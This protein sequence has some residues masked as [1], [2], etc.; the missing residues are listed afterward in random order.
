MKLRLCVM[1]MTLVFAV[2][3]V[4]AVVFAADAE[5]VHGDTPVAA[6]AAGTGDVQEGP[7]VVAEGD[8][9]ADDGL[10]WVYKDDASLTISGAG[11]IPNYYK[12][13]QP[14]N[15][16][17]RTME[18]LA[19]EE[20]VTSIGNYAFYEADYLGVGEI[21]LP[22]TLQAIGNYAFYSCGN[23]KEVTFLA[24]VRTLGS[25]V[26]AECRGITKVVLPDTVVSIGSNSFETCYNVEE[27]VL[28]DGLETIPSNL[29]HTA[30]GSS[31]VTSLK[32]PSNLKRVESGAFQGLGAL[33]GLDLPATLS[34]VGN[35]G[36][37]GCR[38]MGD[39]RIPA[40]IETVGSSA[41]GMFRVQ[42]GTL[43][44]EEGVK[45]SVFDALVDYNVTQASETWVA[46]RIRIPASMGWSDAFKGGGAR[47]AYEVAIG[48]DCYSVVDGV[49]YSRGPNNRYASTGALLVSCPSSMSG[50]FTVAK[51]AL[52]MSYG[53][54]SKLFTVVNIP[55]SVIAI[56][57][58]VFKEAK[59]VDV[60]V[61]EGNATFAS[62]DGI[63]FDKGLTRVI[64]CPKGNA[65]EGDYELPDTVR[66]LDAQAFE[67][68]RNLKSIRIPEGVIAMPNKFM[69]DCDS[70]VAVYLPSTLVSIGTFN[71]WESFLPK[72]RSG[73][74]VFFGGTEDGLAAVK[75]DRSTNTAFDRSKFYCEATWHGTM[76]NGLLWYTDVS[77]ALNIVRDERVDS[78]RSDMADYVAGSAPWSGHLGLFDTVS[79]AS[80]IT[81][82][83]S[84]A[85]AGCP[86]IESVTLSW[87]IRQV[88]SGAFANC[89]SLRTVDCL[90][91]AFSVVAADGQ[92]PSFDADVATLLYRPETTG[93]TDAP[94]YDSQAR[95]WNGYS[96]GLAEGCEL[97][98]IAGIEFLDD[99]GNPVSEATVSGLLGNRQSY[100][101]TDV[102]FSFKVLA[103]DGS[104]ITDKVNVRV[105]SPPRRWS[106]VSGSIGFST[107]MVKNLHL[108]RSMGVS[109]DD[110]DSTVRVGCCSPEG[111]YVITAAP[112]EFESAGDEISYAIDVKRAQERI[113]HAYFKS[114]ET[115]KP[116]EGRAKISDSPYTDTYEVCSQ[117]MEDVTS[118]VQLRVFDVLSRVEVTGALAERGM[119]ASEDS[120]GT[121]Q[122]DRMA[123]PRDYELR[124]GD[125]SGV[126]SG[127]SSL[128]LG[129]KR[130]TELLN[131]PYGI[132]LSEG[133]KAM[134]VDTSA[135]DVWSSIPY[136]VRTLDA[137][138]D[139]CWPDLSW[140]V[141]DSG[142]RDASGG[143]EVDGQGYLRIGKSVLSQIQPGTQLTFSIESAAQGR[144]GIVS[145]NSLPLSLGA[146]PSAPEPVTHV[147]VFK[148]GDDV[149]GR[150]SFVEGDT[151]LVA[152]AV[153]SKANYV[154]TWAVGSV[155]WEEFDLSAA[156]S[157][158]EVSGVYEPIDPD[159]VS[160][161]E[162]D[163]DAK[164]E[165]GAVTVT[166][167]AKAASRNVRIE[168]TKTKPVD[169]V[170]VCDQSG[171]MSDA[172][173]SGQS[174]RDA[175]V[176][177]ANSFAS[178]LSDNAKKTGAG[179]RIALV[180]FGCAGRVYNSDYR[181]YQS[182]GILATNA[183]GF[184]QYPG[185]KKVYSEAL[186]PINEGQS[187][188]P[189]VSQ[190]ISSITCDAAT[191]ANLGFEIAKGIFSQ[192]PSA[193]DASVDGR[194][195]VVVFIT[196]GTPTS[197][198]STDGSQVG[199]T[200]S[201]AI[202]N[203]KYI[204]Q[205]QGARIFSVGVEVAANPSADFTASSNGMSG[206]GNRFSFDFNRFLHAVSS[207]YPEA[208]AM[209]NLGNGSKS[210][211]YYMAVN[212]TSALDGI[213]ESI[214]YST[215][216]TVESFDR[217]SFRYE[218]PEGL[219]LTLKQEEELRA[220]MSGQGM[221][222][223]D[224]SVSRDGGKTTVIFSNVPVKTEREGGIPVYV[225]KVTFRLSA[226]Q[227]SV[228]SMSMGS[229]QVDCMGDE[230]SF[231][232]PSVDVPDDRCLVVFNL[233]GQPYEIRE[234]SMGDSIEAPDTNLARWMGFEKLKDP[235]VTGPIAVF[236]TNSLARTY[237]M[238]W[239]VGEKE[240][241]MDVPPGS[242]IAVPEEVIGWIPE[243]MELAG[244]SPE[245][246]LSM[247]SYDVIC[248][249]VLS[250]KHVHNYD[251]S[252]Y[253]TGDCT[254]GMTVHEVCVCGEEQTYEEAALAAHSFS[255]VLSNEGSYTSPSTQK[256]VCKTCGMSVE[257]DI[258]SEAADD[259]AGV[260]VMD[261]SKLEN[262]QDKA[263]ES[264]DD[265][266]T[267]VYVGDDGDYTVTRIDED[268]TKTDY[269]CWFED[270]YVWFSPDHFS[271]YVIGRKD[272]SGIS[273]SN[274]V[275]YADSLERLA[276]SAEDAPN[277]P[278]SNPDLP[279]V[280]DSG[281]DDGG[282][283]G[284]SGTGVPSEG[285]EQD[286]GTGPGE[287]PSEVR[288]GFIRT[289][290]ALSD[291]GRNGTVSSSLA[292]TGDN[293]LH[294]VV[295][296]GS[297]MLAALVSAGRLART[298]KR[299]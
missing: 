110:I 46:P 200:A 212:N 180:G 214:L 176:E 89:P 155:P 279:P 250:E 90:G 15:A 17:M 66:T 51:G 169:V 196:D 186:M 267:R 63:I 88:K 111:E 140:T 277:D 126:I 148:V 49:L 83:G 276:R 125:A 222:A 40:G 280:V 79:T 33:K 69:S 131:K 173:G 45:P 256:L 34:Y 295:G 127:S 118:R 48:S 289:T 162:A 182:T 156:T 107:D 141:R 157:D 252:T 152:P 185:C 113:F 22:E 230:S 219:A 14:W 296:I 3:S 60:N 291:A 247:P 103:D 144:S 4:P 268:D 198:S 240:M 172:L 266:E 143:F 193:G 201:G 284:G 269:D 161:V 154:G 102:D 287:V 75:I 9:G 47:D 68:C 278:G 282:N 92:S 77:R 80:E 44:F 56:D 32:L 130:S 259:G 61:D 246:P 64:R 117:Y 18:S 95:K 55:S 112:K 271:I 11:A 239:V 174:K 84:N 106:L 8:F 16:Y 166:L 283:G 52:A 30:Y 218:V 134:E 160:G 62:R 58:N 98:T 264:A 81:I 57:T 99:E 39:V 255:A 53:S 116:L 273:A 121:I 215:V 220:D 235:V 12:S 254:I 123:Q 187:I 293:A 10:H 38:V 257:K 233:N 109:F 275:G 137:Y 42:E 171:S 241:A 28:S 263:G 100:T 248:T 146:K 71:F 197:W 74:N 72:G 35:Y 104:D 105:D 292:P 78:P 65:L 163:G 217:A 82:V 285:P 151:S 183:G 27:C 2:M 7:S 178:R 135:E 281:V 262:D 253:K 177:C 145:S 195:R 59:L 190:G 101:R 37:H 25:F 159:A 192:N 299:A 132:T 54:L 237:S 20:G 19:I 175:L 24:S 286:R 265:I 242:A 50:E 298:R 1:A 224:V 181:T 164:H 229:A 236:E 188:N 13:G 225:A 115:S 251:A 272:D 205:S 170:L 244:W 31:V 139:P 138:D 202:Q 243:G 29:F 142:G 85:F 96:L 238:R 232:L 213:F 119:S 91:N 221:K 150:V 122:V 21:G 114:E 43:S 86:N 274:S 133:S 94:A 158:V 194:E 249:A 26:F 228:G 260:I 93:W 73:F 179:H 108:T 203:A 124:L 167:R 288:D 204:K 97:P 6:Y 231:A 23:I 70:L 76:T 199:N 191:A 147:A 206:S 36:F 87:G 5:D 227:G 270:G 209:S 184:S 41:F 297:V 120:P 261:L 189:R 153:P 165:N 258:A 211:G 129:L 234:M 226:I 207:N 223:D 290:V 294:H 136:R 67:E 128:Q 208:S 168:S 216:Y 210:G 149:V 245:Q